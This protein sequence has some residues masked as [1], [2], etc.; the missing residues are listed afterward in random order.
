MSWRALILLGNNTQAYKFALG[1]VLLEVAAAE[2]TEVRL[3][4]I[5]LPFTKKISRHISQADRQGASPSSA[6]L[7]ACR[8]YN[9]GQIDDEALVAIT[10]NQGF[11]YVIDAFHNLPGGEG[12]MRFYDVAGRGVGRRLTLSDDLLR[13]A[14]G[15]QAFNLADE[16]EA[17]WNLVETAW[18]L[19]VNSQ[20]L[21][22]VGYDD[23][24]KDLVIDGPKFRRKPVYG[25]RGVLMGYQ[26]GC[27]FYCATEISAEPGSST[28]ADVDHVVSLDMADFLDL[29]R[30]KLDQT[31]N[32]VL[33]CKNC[34]R[35]QGGKGAKA[36]APEY[37]ETLSRRNEHYIASHH[38][39]RE[40]LI[41]Q[42][43]TNPDARSRIYRAIHGSMSDGGLQRWQPAHVLPPVI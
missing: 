12:K 1:R 4:D 35:G 33:A 9:L 31:W 5:A 14:T 38:P 42:T 39:L 8:A 29:P 2:T 26:K 36:P 21:A 23:E 10:L 13:I 16:V 25:L 43:G 41:A 6:Y 30:E 32:L 27:C 19:G 3:E 40:T 11:R 37:V 34:N 20:F 17:R 28:L 24:R 7:D 22:T 18:E 15:T